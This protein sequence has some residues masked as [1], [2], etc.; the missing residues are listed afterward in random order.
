MQ[1]RYTTRESAREDN[2]A[3]EPSTAN[4]SLT[5]QARVLPPQCGEFLA[6]G[7]REP[8]ASARVDLGFQIKV[9]SGSSWVAAGAG[10]AF[11][12]RVHT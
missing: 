5:P 3:Y 2:G 10:P 4:R 8:G 7:R 11:H 12:D 6:L 9:R 1:A